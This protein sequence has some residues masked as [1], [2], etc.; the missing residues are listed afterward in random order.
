MARPM[1]IAQPVMNGMAYRAHG[2]ILGHALEL[3]IPATVT[4]GGRHAH[5]IDAPVFSWWETITHWQLNGGV[6]VQQVP[7]VGPVDQALGQNQTANW[8]RNRYANAAGEPQWNPAWPRNPG[9]AEAERII[10]QNGLF[11]NIRVYDHPGMNNPRYQAVPGAPRELARS[12]EFY[13]RVG[14]FLIRKTQVLA[15]SSRGD[16]QLLLD[17]THTAAAVLRMLP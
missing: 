2:P 16:R 6:W 4:G 15:S 11:W 10:A 13:I 3:C 5:R 14:A 9:N 8:W 1:Q 12:V 17:G 7:V